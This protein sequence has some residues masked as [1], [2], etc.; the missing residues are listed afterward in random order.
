MNEVIGLFSGIGGLE[1]G[2]NQA[3]WHSSFFCE[4]D[5]FAREVLK[6][7]FGLKD[8]NLCEDVRCLQS[9][10]SGKIIAA[11]FPCQDLSQAGKMAGIKGMRSGLVSE[12]FRLLNMS[13]PP[14]I[15]MENVPFMLRLQ[16]GQAMKYITESLEGF[17]YSWAYRT[18]NTRSFGLPHRRQRVLI[19]ASNKYDP[20][21]VLFNEDYGESVDEDDWETNA[22]GFYWTEG[23]TGVGWAPNHLPPLKCGSS[24]SIPSP[25]AIWIPDTIRT[26]KYRFITPTI[27]DAESLQGF[28][29]KWTKSLKCISGKTERKRWAL[30]GN[31]VS[32]PVAKWIGQR[33]RNYDDNFSENKIRDAKCK[34]S[35][36][37]KAAW[38]SSKGGKWG[39]NVSEWP[40]GIKSKSL[41]E[42]LQNVDKCQPLSLKAAKGFLSRFT[43]GNL[44]AGGARSELIESLR[45]HIRM[46]QG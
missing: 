43:S 2:L 42:F 9:I 21:G 45:R 32:V 46:M 40:V 28:A 14:W 4:I 18:V 41:L 13:K 5:P 38:G 17:G 31:A 30:V 3:E 23:S 22:N 7:N 39:A 6:L 15:L 35:K 10:P 44:K 37:P 1:L 33:I 27:E 26:T 34:F 8:E 29:P 24:I 19:L 25:P 12:I 16:R 36:W 11:G 20:R